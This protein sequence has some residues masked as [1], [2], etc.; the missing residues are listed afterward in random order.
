MSK[1]EGE[2]GEREGREIERER[3]RDVKYL[4]IFLLSIENHFMALACTSNRT[5]HFVYLYSAVHN[6][7]FKHFISNCDPSSPGQEAF[8]HLLPVGDT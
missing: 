2:R 5:Y 4:L 6:D 1:R 7:Y 3:E 8:W